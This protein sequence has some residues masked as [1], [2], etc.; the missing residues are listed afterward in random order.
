MSVVYS[1]LGFIITIIILALVHELGHFYVARKF[2]V[3]VEKFSIGFGPKLYS[4]YDKH[5]TE[6]MLCLIPLGGYVKL[7][8]DEEDNSHELSL[9]HQSLSKKPNYVK[10]LILL[11]GPVANFILAIIVYWWVNVTGINYIV[12]MVDDVPIGTVA[13]QAGLLPGS[14]ITSINGEQVLSWQEINLKLYKL[15]NK[16]NFVKLGVIHNLGDFKEYNLNLTSWHEK[17]FSNNTLATL[18][19]IPFDP[20]SPIIGKVEVNS[21]A[22]EAGLAINDEILYINQQVINS[23]S[24]LQYYIRDK[25]N[26]LLTLSILRDGEKLSLVITPK[27]KL[28]DGGQTIGYLGVGF[29]SMPWP[30][31]FIRKHQYGFIDGYN[32]AVQTTLEHMKTTYI[33]LGN[34]LTGVMSWDN[35]SGPIAIAEGAGVS[36]KAGLQS[37]FS[38]LAMLS[39]SVGI[40]NLLPL[41]FLDGGQLMLVFIEGIRG[42][43]LPEPVMN[44]INKLGVILI[45]SIMFITIF[46]DLIS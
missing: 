29:K 42:K 36:V 20:I 37:Y 43:Q 41:P 9:M 12:P 28:V 32:K 23:R 11:A 21:P 26:V 24:E 33:L 40:L 39:I 38:F 44:I 25:A 8:G 30:K 34:I 6:F 13:Y 16:D 35:L 2:K 46:Y 10:A 27:P 18:G 17:L 5:N 45:L 14:V 1:V 4:F 22:M 31:E 19:I 7:F 15:L 3:K